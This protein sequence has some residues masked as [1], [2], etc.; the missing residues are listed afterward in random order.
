MNFISNLKFV[1]INNTWTL[2]VCSE[3]KIFSFPQN[4]EPM[5]K[6]ALT[7]FPEDSFDAPVLYSG[8]AAAGNSLYIGDSNGFIYRFELEEGANIT[9]QNIRSKNNFISLGKSIT[10]MEMLEKTET[11]FIGCEDGEL[12]VVDC[13]TGTRIGS[14]MAPMLK[15]MITQLQLLDDKYLIG[16]MSN[17]GVFMFGIQQNKIMNCVVNHSK[18][19]TSVNGMA[20][21]DGYLIAS[22]SDDGI[23]VVIKWVPHDGKIE[24]KVCKNLGDRAI[25]GVCI[26]K[27]YVIAT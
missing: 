9:K 1:Q 5:T 10:S 18:E 26:D 16:G 20:D 12:I 22:G 15:A 4:G 17:G 25:L 19:V 6:L 8:I 11:L 2:I 24:V 23:L 7:E 21:G 3:S 13:K 27:K 14:H